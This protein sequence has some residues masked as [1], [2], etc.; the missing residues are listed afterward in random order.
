[1]R[2]ASALRRTQDWPELLAA[3]IEARREAPF[4]WGEQD[5]CTLAADA[6]L[7]FTGVDPMAALRGS[8][9]SEA[10]AEAILAGQGGLAELAARQAAA[11]GL[12][13]CH[14]AFAQRGDVALVEH[15]NT[16]AMGVVVGAAV[17]VPGPDGLLF[18]P[19]AAIQRAW[20]V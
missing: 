4:A 9:A 20:S 18:L 11:V 8:Y 3:L 15:G 2:A 7:A 16:L 14:P 12:G 13:D 1:M 19:P 10:E 17:A 6:V 5:C